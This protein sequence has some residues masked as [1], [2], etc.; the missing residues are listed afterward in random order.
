MK[1][2]I[3]YGEQTSAAIRNFPFPTHKVHLELIYSITEIKKAAALAHKKAQELDTSISEAIAQA[4]DEILS[5][6][7][8]DQF[9]TVAIQGG[10]GTSINMNVNEVIANRAKEICGISVHPNDHVNKSQ[11]TNDVNPSA[12][13]I[14]CIRLTNDLIKN[15]DLLI[16]TFEEKALQYKHIPK[17]GRTHIQDAVPTTFGSVFQSYADILKRN[18]NRLEDTIPYL[19]ELN[20]GGT[21]IGNS[22]NA[23]DN[24]IKNVYIELKGITNLSLHKAQN[25]MSQTSS[26]SDF[27]HLSAAINILFTDISKIAT[28]IRFL[29][30]GPLGGIGEINLKPLQKGS[31]IM[32]GKINPIIPESMNQ[33]AYDIIG[34][35]ITIHQAAQHSFL[36]LS[37]MFPVLADS[38]ISMLK[39]ASSGI[40]VFAV[41]CIQFIEPDSERAKELLEN[42]TVYAT[43]FVPKLG[44]DTVTEIVKEAVSTKKTLREV[45]IRKKLL[46]QT[47]F[48]KLTANI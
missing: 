6:N 20:L 13:K 11:S 15:L 29:S 40:F 10:A 43:L 26:S 7:F 35:N 33:I 46:D 22:I 14:A 1:N 36:E 28:D 17:I 23:S 9:M 21:A 19:Y 30:S 3:Y 47:N 12:L 48:E 18:K 34:K 2:K 39:L 8:D 16:N 44:Y 32:P 37:L 4:A 45:I 25:L 5:G 41:N 27:C 38:I 24:Y 31:S 42:S